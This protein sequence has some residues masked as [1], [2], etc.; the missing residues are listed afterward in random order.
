MNYM[1]KWGGCICMNLM[2]DNFNKHFAHWDI[3]IPEENMRTRHG[4]Y[5]QQGG[6]LIQYCFGK[7]ETDKEYL[8]YYAAHRMTDDSHK[9]IYEDGREEFLPSLTSKYLLS[10]DPIKAKKLKEEYEEHNR[11]V[12]ELLIEKGFDRFTINMFLH[13]GMDK[14]TKK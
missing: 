11:K 9:R 2:R 14:E 1:D 4:G 10:D 3:I 8:D 6:W 5:I 12:V 7:D 13:A